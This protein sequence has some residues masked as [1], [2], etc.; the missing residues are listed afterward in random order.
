MSFLQALD[1]F[2]AFITMLLIKLYQITLSPDKGI[3]SPILKGKI[4]SHE[5]HCSEYA[6]R[7]LKRYGF[8]KGIG[9]VT[10]RILHCKPRRKKMYDPEYYRIVFFSSAPIG[11]PFLE[12]LAKDK[13]FEIVG[14][15]TQADKPVGRGL[16]VQENIITTTAKGL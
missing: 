13:R 6:I 3:F 12:E 15:V 10:D 16:R 4:C 2:L 11:V 1:R 5:P 9:K 8:W 14:V 7:T